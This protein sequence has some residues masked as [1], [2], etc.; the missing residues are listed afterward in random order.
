MKEMNNT[1]LIYKKRVSIENGI[2]EYKF[3]QYETVNIMVF[4]DLHAGHI[5]FN[6][7][8]FE[9]YLDTALQKPVLVLLNGDLMECGTRYSY[10]TFEQNLDQNEQYKYII[11]SFK[12]IADEGRLIG[13]V[14]GNHEARISRDNNRLDI[15]GIIADG[16]GV[17]NFK[18]AVF[19]K[20]FLENPNN[21]R[22]RQS[23][24]IY[25]THGRSGARMPGGKLNAVLYMRDV[26]NADI[27]IMSHLH[28]PQTYSTL[29]YD[30]SGMKR[31]QKNKQY[32]CT[33]SFL[34]YWDSYAHEQNVPPSVIGVPKIKFHAKFHRISVSMGG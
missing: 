23:Y 9:R 19:I 21:Y 29:A 32:V 34:E 33:G 22:K 6:K 18:T 7:N 1:N 12:P 4:S 24:Q 28:T 14:N 16:L 31:I 13:L 3:D 5:N 15:T 25:A 11:E 8:I 26:A 17:P 27:Y 30:T 20:L 10:G 2:I